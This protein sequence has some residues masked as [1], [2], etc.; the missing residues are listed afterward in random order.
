MHVYP[1]LGYFPAQLYGV[2]F[3]ARSPRT[4]ANRFYPEVSRLHLT[5]RRLLAAVGPAAQVTGHV[6]A[7]PGTSGHVPARRYACTSARWA[8]SGDTQPQTARIAPTVLSGLRGLTLNLLR[9]DLLGGSLFLGR[10]TYHFLRGRLLCRCLFR[11]P[12]RSASS[13]AA[14]SAADWHSGHLL[15][16]DPCRLLGGEPGSLLVGRRPSGILLGQ[17]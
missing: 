4:P 7:R 11:R 1:P 2:A 9:G 10:M 8:V 16:L 3:G 15:R 14:W 17:P 12:C 6:R 5:G 13:A